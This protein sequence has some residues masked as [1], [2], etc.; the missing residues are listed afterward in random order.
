[1]PLTAV[2]EISNVKPGAT[3]TDRGRGVETQ[4]GRPEGSVRQPGFL[5]PQD[6]SASFALL[7]LR[8]LIGIVFVV[9]GAQKLFVLGLP[10]FAMMLTQMG[11]PLPPVAAVLVTLVELV[12]GVLLIFGLFA[13][14][15][16]H[17]DRG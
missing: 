16:G 15:V 14:P 1:M 12:G 5:M 11:V 7:L 17:P 4:L 10:R 9:H 3:R 8:V 2:A 13:R 6:R